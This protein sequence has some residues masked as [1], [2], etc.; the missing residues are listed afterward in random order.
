M[1][2]VDG[3]PRGAHNE[4]SDWGGHLIALGGHVVITG[5]GQ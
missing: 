5:G 1:T 4:A 3:T 2:S